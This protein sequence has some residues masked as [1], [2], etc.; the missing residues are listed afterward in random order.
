[1]RMRKIKQ[2]GYAKIRGR[3]V[4]FSTRNPWTVV[5]Y[6]P[7]EFRPSR[8]VI[9]FEKSKTKEGRKLSFTC[10]YETCSKLTHHVFT[11]IIRSTQA[12]SFDTGVEQSVNNSGARNNSIVYVTGYK[13]TLKVACPEGGLV[14]IKPLMERIHTLLKH[15]KLFT[16]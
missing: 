9:S 14:S 12:R 7:N 3:T 8:W 15:N 13:E 5:F 6:F 16:F 2:N 10:G 1:M 4:Y 11:R